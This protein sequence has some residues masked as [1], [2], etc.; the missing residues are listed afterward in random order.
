MYFKIIDAREMNTIYYRQRTSYC[1]DEG[2]NFSF[3]ETKIKC[4]SRLLLFIS[5]QLFIGEVA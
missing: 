1:H 2:Q 4:I 3:R 5:S